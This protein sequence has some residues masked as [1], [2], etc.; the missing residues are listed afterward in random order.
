M[1]INNFNTKFAIYIVLLGLFIGIVWGLL[2]S[3]IIVKHKS[4]M[5]LIERQDKMLEKWSLRALELCP[6]GVQGLEMTF[7]EVQL[8]CDV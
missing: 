5:L 6:F 8:T 2:L 3:L 7:G 4:N 1:F